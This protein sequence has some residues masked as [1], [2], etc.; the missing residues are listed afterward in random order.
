MNRF[1]LAG[2]VLIIFCSSCNSNTAGGPATKSN[3][4]LAVNDIDQYTPP[5]PGTIVATDSMPVTDDPLNHFTFSVK[6]KANEY[7]KK[8]TY[9]ILAS[10]GPNEG[11][12]MFTMPRGGGNLKPV[13]RR[14]K[15]AYTYII[16]FEYQHK[17]YEYY[18]VSGSKGTIEIKNIKAYSFQ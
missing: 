6:I 5:P 16:G 8:G 3:S 14:S 12:G 13:L 18:K 11:N 9:S 1:L 10:Y 17:F 2:F 4:L 15:E 7:S